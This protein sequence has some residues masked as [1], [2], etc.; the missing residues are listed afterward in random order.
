MTASA[1][2]A[3]A[4]TAAAAPAS[5]MAFTLCESGCCQ[6]QHNQAQECRV[7]PFLNK[8]AHNTLLKMNF[9]ARGTRGESTVNLLHPARRDDGKDKTQDYCNKRLADADE[10]DVEQERGIRRNG[11]WIAHRTVAEITRDREL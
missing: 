1:A 5:S 3:A 8:S 7:S 6:E 9:S 10:F 2:A 11:G 4:A